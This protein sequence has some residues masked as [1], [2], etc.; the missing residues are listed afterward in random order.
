MVLVVRPELV[1][2]LVGPELYGPVWNLVSSRPPLCRSWIGTLSHTPSR[3]GILTQCL[4]DVDTSDRHGILTQCRAVVALRQNKV[5]AAILSL[6]HGTGFLKN[7]RL[8]VSCCRNSTYAWYA[9]CVR[10]HGVRVVVS[11]TSRRS[12]FIIFE[13]KYLTNTVL[14][15]VNTVLILYI[16]KSMQPWYATCIILHRANDCETPR[17]NAAC[18]T[19]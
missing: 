2:I 4:S 14:I 1:L 19:C 10:Q 12:A 7:R 17:H 13:S 3:H 8:S 18:A 15:V 16:P 5:R 9:L 6:R 11:V